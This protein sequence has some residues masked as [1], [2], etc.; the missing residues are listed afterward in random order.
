MFTDLNIIWV[1]NVWF[2]QSCFV[3][4]THLFIYLFIYSL[5]YLSIYVSIQLFILVWYVFLFIL[6]F[7]FE[8]RILVHLFCFKETISSFLIFHTRHARLNWLLRFLN[9]ILLS[10]HCFLHFLNASKWLVSW[11]PEG[12][13]CNSTMFRWEP[14]GRY[15]CT[16]SYSVGLLFIMHLIHTQNT[17]KGLWR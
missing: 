10:Y 3:L 6:S 2:I 11:E 13:Y 16:K 4:L 17:K 9:H 5:F 15:C 7:F 1:M 12:R 14:E 8:S